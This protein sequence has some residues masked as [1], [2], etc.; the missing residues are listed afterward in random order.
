MST[1]L[2]PIDLCSSLYALGILKDFTLQDLFHLF[3]DIR[4]QK[5]LANITLGVSSD[6]DIVNHIFE[7][8]SCMKQTYKD[9]HDF[10]FIPQ[11]SDFL[12]SD[13]IIHGLTPSLFSKM[14]SGISN[15]SVLFR[16]L[17]DSAKHFSKFLKSGPPLSS[18]YVLNFSSIWLSNMKK[19]IEER[20]AIL[21]GHIK[22][23]LI[24]ASIQQ[25]FSCFPETSMIAF[26]NEEVCF[27]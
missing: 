9:I 3:L 5:I 4:R 1:K 12:K 15:I 2:S 18:T 22:T 20:L 13:S 16:Y 23:G 26:T 8:V 24:L 21:L 14:Y 17:P 25:N 11:F 6:V 7:F 19:S 10:F 27:C